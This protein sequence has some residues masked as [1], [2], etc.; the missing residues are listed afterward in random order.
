[1]SSTVHGC[2]FVTGGAG[3]IGSNF[4]RLLMKE[5]STRVVVV[6]CLTYAGNLA[7]L[8]PFTTDPRFCFE[9]VDIAD[10]DSIS[11][12]FGK[13]RP[14][15]VVNFAAES[16]VDRSIDGPGDF[17]RTNIVGVFTLLECT[18]QYLQ[19]AESD[20]GARSSFRF[21]QVSTDEVY[22]SLGST[23]LFREDT[24]Y[25]PNSPY[26][27]SKASADHLVRAWHET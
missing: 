10:R 18:R 16:H 25:A 27:A 17:I 7:N 3:F 2:T 12:L 19:K 15:A 11:A 9:Q 23:G 22:G 13:H 20:G 4:V 24:P 1:V 14:D 5:R 26:A 21:L 6:D 8:E